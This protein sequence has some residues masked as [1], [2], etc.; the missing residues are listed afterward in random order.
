[1]GQLRGEGRN[2]RRGRPRPRP[3]Q[4][5][6]GRADVRRVR[7]EAAAL[8]RGDHLCE[9][10]RELRG[11]VS[12]EP[13]ERAYQQFSIMGTALQV[14]L[15]MWPANIGVGW[16]IQNELCLIEMRLWSPY[17]LKAKPKAA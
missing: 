4:R 8:G 2:P 1:M 16:T 11:R 9:P 13:G 7:P 15:A 5:Q 6:R 14:L 12:L 10:D 3:R 17:L